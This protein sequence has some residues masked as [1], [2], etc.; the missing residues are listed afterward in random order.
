[1]SNEEDLVLLTAKVMGRIAYFIIIGFLASI[2][3]MF[4]IPIPGGN[5][6]LIYTS[7]GWLGSGVTVIISYYFVRKHVKLA[8]SKNVPAPEL[9]EVKTLPPKD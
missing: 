2:A 5:R 6:E 1:M 3:A 8:S 4:Y 7:V 9:P